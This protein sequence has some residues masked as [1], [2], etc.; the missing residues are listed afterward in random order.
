[1]KAPKKDKSKFLH[2]SKTKTSVVHL[3]LLYK[4]FSKISNYFGEFEDL[5]ITYYTVHYIELRFYR[6]STS[7]RN[8]KADGFSA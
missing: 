7:N 6:G 3:I 2:L 4:L 8:L 5:L 1:M